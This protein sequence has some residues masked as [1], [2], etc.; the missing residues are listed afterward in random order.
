VLHSGFCF[1]QRAVIWLS[2]ITC[3]EETGLSTMGPV[4]W[5]NGAHGD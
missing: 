3:F 2:G 1:T 5:D 4:S